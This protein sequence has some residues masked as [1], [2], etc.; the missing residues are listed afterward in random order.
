MYVHTNIHTV[1]F[2]CGYTQVKNAGVGRHLFHVL[3]ITQA[4]KARSDLMLVTDRQGRLQHVTQVGHCN[5][6]NV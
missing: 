6:V 1:C 5:D 3:Q 2:A 4:A